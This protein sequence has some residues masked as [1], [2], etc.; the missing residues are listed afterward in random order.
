MI[1]I[2]RILCPID[3]S[4]SS[5]HAV[6]HAVAIA[7]RYESTVTLLHVRPLMSAAAYAPGIPVATV[8]LSVATPAD[9]QAVLASMKRFTDTPIA[10]GVPIVFEI[11][12]GNTAS[13]ILDR[14]VTMPSDLIIMGTHGRSGVE[15]FMLGSVT[16]EVIHK[17]LCPVLT[18]PPGIDD[19]AP[20]GPLLF[21]RILCA[22]DFSDAS[23]HALEYAVSLAQGP[24]V[25]L[26]VMHVVE[27][28][29][30]PSSPAEVA[31][32]SVHE[33]RALDAY[34]AT[35]AQARAEQLERII[36][37]SVRVQC[38]VKTT[39]AIGR[40]HREILRVAGEHASDIIVLGARGFGVAQLLFGS[41]VHQVVRHAH[42]P[43]LTIR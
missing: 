40:S 26:T 22:V 19:V 39:L 6:D 30:P 28:M 17:A 43:V 25:R 18:V 23:L 21:T 10:T 9:H 36:P 14:S 3:F 34:V 4:D 29:P 24:D 33:S 31:G 8:P 16:E 38:E 5:R 12:D 13:E 41:T 2:H 7:K 27:V 1:H 32:A 11:G 35:A 20:T 42:C 37:D 15:R